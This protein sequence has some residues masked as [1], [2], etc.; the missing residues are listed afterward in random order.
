MTE[1]QE[2]HAQVIAAVWGDFPNDSNKTLTSAGRLHEKSNP[3]AKRIEKLL[4]FYENVSGT[5]DC[6]EL[7]DEHNRCWVSLFTVEDIRDQFQ[8]LDA[9]ILRSAA[10]TSDE[11]WAKVWGDKKKDSAGV[12]TNESDEEE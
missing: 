11:V 9:K 5:E 7:W 6:Y 10:R 2:D 3:Y 1:L 8:R 4:S 12:R